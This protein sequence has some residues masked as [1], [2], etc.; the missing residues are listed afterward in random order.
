MLILEA[1]SPCHESC[2]ENTM[3]TWWK[4]HVLFYTTCIWIGIFMIEHKESEK[5][6]KK[7]MANTGWQRKKIWSWNMCSFS[8]S[9][10]YLYS[11]KRKCDKCLQETVNH[12]EQWVAFGCSCPLPA[13][14]LGTGN[15]IWLT[16]KERCSPVDC[17]L[18]M[19]ARTMCSQ[20]LE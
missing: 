12:L 3:T 20:S 5:L 16:L 4:M 19:I 15:V 1:C 13:M 10:A 14:F 8:R 2:M 7:W 6:V 18:G 17:I 11:Y 9:L